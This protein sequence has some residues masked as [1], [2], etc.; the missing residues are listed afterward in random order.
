VSITVKMEHIR[1]A[2]YC[3]AGAKV[4]LKHHG[5]DIAEFLR[6]GVPVERIEGTGDAM[7]L[8]VAAIAR[9]RA[10]G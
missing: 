10:H 4:W 8:K 6:E 2:R 1:A 5:I 9:E 3:S 7:G